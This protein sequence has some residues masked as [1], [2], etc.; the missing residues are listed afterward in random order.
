MASIEIKSG[1]SYVKQ[2][3]R[4]NI[5]ETLATICFEQNLRDRALDGSVNAVG[6]HLNQ[7]RIL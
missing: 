7:S 4:A 2:T 5:E 3:I 6:D 1:P